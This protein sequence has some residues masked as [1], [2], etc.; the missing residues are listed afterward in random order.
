VVAEWYNMKKSASLRVQAV[1]D[2]VAEHLR[3][4]GIQAI[5][6]EAGA[7]PAS[8][9]GNTTRFVDINPLLLKMREIKYDDEIKAIQL[10]IQAAEVAHAACRSF[11]RSGI[12]E[13]D[14]LG[15]LLEK[16]ICGTGR[17]VI[18]LCDIVSGERARSGGGPPSDRILQKG[19]LILLD[20]FPIVEGYRGD[21]TNTLSVDGCPTAA[22][23]EAFALVAEALKAGEQK[24]APGAPVRDI[25]FAM[26]EALR[27]P[28][29]AW[30]LI[31]H[32]GHGLGLEHPEPP[33]IV[34]ESDRSL[35]EGMVITLEPG[36]YHDS[37]GGIRLENNYLITR[38]GYCKLS[39]HHL[40]L[41]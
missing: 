7:L 34:P 26:D 6:G 29:R 24:L 39:Q 12:R 1:A 37:F 25:F 31:H 17:P 23:E 19:D 21:I 40:G 20:F 18:M 11:V 8:V 33:H 2:V 4:W 28:G 27:R 22:Q 3:R 32:G 41:K 15:H 13:I 14:V 9:A 5:A 38:D 36:L 16:S 30:S 35:A 10:A